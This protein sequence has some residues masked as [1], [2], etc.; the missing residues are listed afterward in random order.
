MPKA[1]KKNY[2][3]LADDDLRKELDGLVKGLFNLRVRKVTDVVE[4]PAAFRQH[5]REIAR[6]RT[7]IRRRE[8]SAAASKPAAAAEKKPATPPAAVA[9]AKTSKTSKPAKASKAA[10]AP[11]TGR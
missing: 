9:P 5:R 10:P 3:D 6:I 1:G 11:P 7:E 4:N 8:L 2:R